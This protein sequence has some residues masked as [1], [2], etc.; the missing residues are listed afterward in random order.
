[1]DEESNVVASSF[2]SK[3]LTLAEK[4]FLLL[5]TRL[6]VGVFLW[7][8]CLAAGTRENN[9]LIWLVVALKYMYIETNGLNCD[10]SF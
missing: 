1:M 7:L 6:H 3:P 4:S 8:S 5:L 9:I 2:R 10:K